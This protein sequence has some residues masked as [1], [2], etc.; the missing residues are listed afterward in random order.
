MRTE[1]MIDLTAPDAQIEVQRKADRHTLEVRRSETALPA[2]TVAL[3]Y[4]AFVVGLV[5]GVLLGAVLT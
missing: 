3:V 4:L 1:T 5:L 2:I